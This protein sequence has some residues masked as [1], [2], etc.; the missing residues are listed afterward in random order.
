MPTEPDRYDLDQMMDRLKQRSSDDPA[1]ECE[2]VTRADGSK[3]I[4]V[5][6]RKRRSRQPHKE[7]KRRTR[8]LQ[9][10]ALLVLALLALLAAGFLTIYVNTAPYRER[11]TQQIATASGA[12]VELQQFRMNPIGA[13]AMRVDL[14]WPEGNLLA[15]LS[16]RQLSADVSMFSSLGGAMAGDELE[17][18]TATLDL[19]LPVAG[20]SMRHTSRAEGDL[21]IRFEDWGINQF[22]VRANVDQPGAWRLVNSE[23]FFQSDGGDGHPILNLNDG[24]LIAKGWPKL[25]L[26]RGFLEFKGREAEVLGISLRHSE[27]DLGRLDL[28]GTLAPYSSEP[29][30]LEIEAESFLLSGL[31]GEPLGKLV[32]GRV[33]AASD[34]SGNVL[35]VDFG[36]QAG[37]TLR[38]DFKACQD[39]VFIIQRLPCLYALSQTLGDEWFSQPSFVETASGRIVSNGQRVELRD[40]DCISHGRMAI[41]GN[42]AVE[43]GRLSGNLQLGVANGMIQSSLNPALEAMFGA[44]RGSYRWV[45]IEL[46]GPVNLPEDNFGVLYDTALKASKDSETSSGEAAEGAD[47]EGEGSVFESLTQP[48]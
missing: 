42:L 25:R 37:A 24:E 36:E 29:S 27:D 1:E 48:R 8:M 19:R 38:M 45:E 17:A 4:R 22:E 18:K 15:S 31:V 16:M 28:T 43:S 23:A 39:Q 30:R 6:R 26:K 12:E 47:G 41:R 5:K 32:S 46:S 33:D 44:P 34:A 10:S 21:P 9:V 20:K 35:E 7:R 11:L 14:Q 40:L 13:N 2:L 3:A